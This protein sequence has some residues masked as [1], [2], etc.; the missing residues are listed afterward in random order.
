MA[1]N[2]VRTTEDRTR[3]PGGED[4]S[5]RGAT[6]GDGLL[7]SRTHVDRA[8]TTPRRHATAERD[9]GPPSIRTGER[10]CGDV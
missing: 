10:P 3:I 5:V 6:P 7:R 1:V 2:L 8:W 4:L 9:R